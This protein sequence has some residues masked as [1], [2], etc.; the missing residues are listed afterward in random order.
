MTYR[1]SGTSS[2]TGGTYSWPQPPSRVSGGITPG[3]RGRGAPLEPSMREVQVSGSAKGWLIP[4]IYGERDV[5]GQ[6]IALHYDDTSHALYNYVLLVYLISEGELNSISNI[7]LN[8]TDIDD[9]GGVV[10]YDSYVGAPT[11]AIDGV[12][13]GSD[14]SSD[15]IPSWSDTHDNGLKAVTGRSTGRAYFWVRLYADTNTTI[16]TMTCTATRGSVDDW[17]STSRASSNPV[18]ALWSYMSEHLGLTSSDID[19]T[20][21]EAERVACDAD[22]GDGTER[23]SLNIALAG[24]SY[25]TCIETILQH[26][27][28][29]MTWF[30]GKLYLYSRR[31]QASAALDVG[32]DQIVNAFQWSRVP[33]HERPNYVEVLFTDA[34][35]GQ[36]QKKVSSESGIY[37]NSAGCRQ[38]QINLPGCTEPSMAARYAEQFRLLNKLEIINAR[39]S[40]NAEGVK[41]NPGDRVDITTPTGLSA[42]AFRINRIVSRPSGVYELAVTSYDATAQSAATDTGDTPPS[43]VFPPTRNQDAAAPTF[44]AS[45]EIFDGYSD[46]LGNYTVTQDSHAISW[47]HGT[48]AG[49]IVGWAFDTRLSTHGD[50]DSTITRMPYVHYVPS[51]TSVYFSDLGDGDAPL[52]TVYSGFD[53]LR[54]V[55]IGANGVEVPGN[56]GGHNRA[57]SSSTQT[58]G[59]IMLDDTPNSRTGNGLKLLREN[60]GETALEYVSPAGID[61]DAIHKNVAGEINAL[62]NVTPTNLDRLILE[63]ESDSHNKKE[64]QIGQMGLALVGPIRTDR[65]TTGILRRY[66][67][68]KDFGYGASNTGAFVIRP[69]GAAAASANTMFH[70]TIHGYTW[71]ATGGAQASGAMQVIIGGYVRTSPDWTPA[72]ASAVVTGAAPF[73]Q[74]RLSRDASGYH[75]IVIGTTST[76]WKYWTGSIDIQSM[77]TG[78][79]NFEPSNLTLAFDSSLTSF[80]HDVNMT[81]L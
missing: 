27:F 11:Q 22:P 32:Q 9:F 19:T 57:T 80:T 29:G 36:Q 52:Q 10:D 30:D 3:Y 1:A 12:L 61:T 49:A 56:W 44:G 51:A 46:P 55:A 58:D 73:T 6:L 72:G 7:K 75:A 60:V 59:F 68:S 4:R 76:V 14:A 70:I 77:Y 24:S 21:W 65:N 66:I 79:N 31:A 38:V 23:W 15:G 47:T 81:G 48:P 2:P 40:I 62:T 67:S 20:S 16:P 26:F 25:Q 69:F 28:G 18:V 41:L 39:V 64:T 37:P 78:G 34:T 17:S 33:L 42:S 8:G 45:G 43:T 5:A 54:I 50:P 74:V 53:Q 71:D 35:S 13:S 63:D